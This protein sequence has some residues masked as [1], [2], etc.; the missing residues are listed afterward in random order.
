V[1]E[2]GQARRRVPASRRA[3]GG[4]QAAVERGGAFRRAGGSGDGVAGAAK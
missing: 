4:E 3:R 1:V 2:A